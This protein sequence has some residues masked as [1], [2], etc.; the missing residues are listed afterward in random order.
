MKLQIY[1]TKLAGRLLAAPSKSYAH[2]AIIAAA[3]ADGVSQIDNVAKSDDVLA[4]IAVL[5]AFGCNFQWRGS[6]LLVQSS[7]LQT[8]SKVLNCRESASTLRFILPLSL[9]VKGPCT[10]SGQPSLA[11]RPLDDYLIL[12]NKHNCQIEYNG[13]LPLTISGKPLCGEVAIAG[14][15]S[16]QYISGLMFALPLC[17]QPSTI[18]LTTALQSRG[19][20]DMTI[21]VLRRFGI[22]IEPLSNGWQIAAN[23]RYQSTDFTVE[24]DFS[25]AAYWLV[26]ATLGQTIE[27]AEL[28]SESLQ[29]DRAI[30]D[31]INRMGGA[32]S[33]TTTGF[34]AKPAKTRG[35]TLDVSQMVDLVPAIALLASVSEGQ[36][37]LIGGARLRYKESN[38]LESVVTQLNALGAD[39][40]ET[41][42]GMV[43]RGRRRLVGGRVNSCADHRIAMMLTIAATVCDQPVILSAAEVV[44][45]SYPQFYQDFAALGGNYEQYNR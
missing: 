13:R 4:T 1:P 16:S 38:R 37:T 39:I 23:Q 19:Y 28:S 12:F 42:D 45:K 3:L 5:T 9:Q 24:G 10:F 14:N 26:A 15:I 7:A 6:S 18:R 43:I 33:A 31:V 41:A 20:V 32:V 40:E 44:A 8:P 34:I 17:D 36:T 27:V 11:K 35:I 2:R 30:V 25:S 29:G 22:V 21:A